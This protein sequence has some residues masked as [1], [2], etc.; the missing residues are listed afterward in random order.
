MKTYINNIDQRCQWCGCKDYDYIENGYCN[1]CPKENNS[2]TTRK[3][4]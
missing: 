4:K 1:L 3:E 2:E